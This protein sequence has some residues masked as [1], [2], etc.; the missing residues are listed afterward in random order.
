MRFHPIMVTNIGRYRLSHPNLLKKKRA[1]G[2]T[3]G[4]AIPTKN[5]EAGIGRTL[6]FVLD[7]CSLFD[8]IAVFDSGSTD[9]TISVAKSRG[10]DAYLDSE[11]ASS[12]KLAQNGWRSGKGFNMW[13]ATEFLKTDIILYLDAD[14]GNLTTQLCTAHAGPL[15]CDPRIQ[16]A[17]SSFVLPE[18]DSKATKLMTEPILSCFYPQI[19][20][21]IYDPLSGMWGGRR[22]FLRSLHFPTGYG[23][24]VSTL[25]Q[26]FKELDYQQ[27]GQVTLTRISNDP[28]NIS[29][30]GRMAAS[31]LHT[32]LHH[33]KK[34]GMIRSSSMHPYLIQHRADEHSNQYRTEQFMVKDIMLK[35]MVRYTK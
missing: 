7:N 32:V 12:L 16:Y 23:V 21:Q 14:L 22:E 31:I 6:D 1:L 10:V 20:S 9:N 35:P 15:L 29:H 8:K 33:A 2:L 30:Y 17:K 26:A 4:L 13:A 27:I 25:I 18:N 28:R 24:E 34:D 5:E 19:M 11:I 3:I